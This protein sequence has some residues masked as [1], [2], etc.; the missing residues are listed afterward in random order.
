VAH[1][2]LFP[3]LAALC[4]GTAPSGLRG[5][6]LMPLLEGKMGDHPG[7]AYSE[8]HA[9]GTCTGS[10]MIRRGKWKYIHYT[11]YASLL[12]NMETDPGEMKDLIETDE[13]KRVSK[14]LHQILISLVDP[15]AVTERAFSVQENKLHDLCAHNTLD[16][17]LA[18]GFEKRLGRGQAIT[19][20]SK[21]IK[22]R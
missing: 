13:G 19:L 6:S 22:K 17:L 2:D 7:Y 5:Y 11:Y 20:L 4:G 8:L 14:D 12:F 16:E 15:T 18:N 21:Y 3:T 10:F 1:V 9:E